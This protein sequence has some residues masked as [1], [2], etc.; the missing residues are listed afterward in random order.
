MGDFMKKAKDFIGRH[1]QQVDQGIRK[2]GD[3]TNRRTGGKYEGKVNKA[4]EQAQRATG[5][6]EQQGR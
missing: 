6:N 3:E 4:A 5:R 1:E 2:A